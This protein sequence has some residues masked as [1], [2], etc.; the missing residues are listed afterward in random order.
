[1]KKKNI[2]FEQLS[3]VMAFKI[4]VENIDECYLCLKTIHTNYPIVPGR[5]KDYI[6][7]PKQKQYS[8]LLPTT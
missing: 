1:M 5:F 6:S 4:I 8:S 7:L 3:D 2:S